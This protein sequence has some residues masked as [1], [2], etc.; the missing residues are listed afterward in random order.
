VQ[1][2]AYST[3]RPLRAVVHRLKLRSGFRGRLGGAA[4]RS[5][6][7]G[8]YDVVAAIVTYDEPTEL[9]GKYA[10]YRLWIAA[11]SV[12]QPGGER[13]QQRGG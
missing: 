10:P 12:Q 11:D 4:L 9:L 7:D 8:D 6:L 13:V 3:E 5:I 1:L 2:V